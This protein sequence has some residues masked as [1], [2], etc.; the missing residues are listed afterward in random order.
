MSLGDKMVGESQAGVLVNAVKEHP[1]LWDSNSGTTHGGASLTVNT[2]VLNE[3]RSESASL[4]C[5]ESASG[6]PLKEANEIRNKMEAQ[7]RSG[8]SR[9]PPPSASFRDK[10]MASFGKTH[11]STTERP[12]GSKGDSTQLPMPGNIK[13]AGS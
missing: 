8:S 1:P 4:S 12:A 11:C 13:A 9:P 5:F 7:L 3:H 10:G 6:R 2:A